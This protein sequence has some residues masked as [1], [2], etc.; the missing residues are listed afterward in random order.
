MDVYSE[1]YVHSAE[2]AY[3]QDADGY[4]TYDTY[5]TQPPVF[6]PE[7]TWY[8]DEYEAPEINIED[9]YYD[10]EAEY[11]EDGG[12]DVWLPYTPPAPAQPASSP[13]GGAQQQVVLAGLPGLDLGPGLGIGVGAA[14]PANGDMSESYCHLH[15]VECGK[16]N[17]SMQLNTTD[18]TNGTESEVPGPPGGKVLGRVDLSGLGMV[19][20]I[21][22]LLLVGVHFGWDSE[23]KPGEKGKSEKGDASKY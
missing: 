16:L 5:H 11:Y 7:E 22:L 8:E 6:V 13:N 2:Y 23:K 4:D 17:G 14:Y 3:A 15:P 21:G 18:G 9:E 10:P 20:L 1:D 19:L 12:E